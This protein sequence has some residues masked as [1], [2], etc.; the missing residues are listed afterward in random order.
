MHHEWPFPA[1][2][3]AQPT[4]RLQSV[5]RDRSLVVAPG[6]TYLFFGN[7]SSVVNASSSL[8]R[9]GAIV[10]RVLRDKSHDADV[11]GY[12]TCKCRFLGVLNLG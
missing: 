2:T 5:G 12:G 11:S 4:H 7:A 3:Q 6:A 8:T 1:V 10:L 9:Y